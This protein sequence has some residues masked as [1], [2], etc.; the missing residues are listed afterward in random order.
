[1]A[2]ANPQFDLVEI[3]MTRK[4]RNMANVPHPFLN[5]V[6]LPH[7]E[8]VLVDPLSD[9]AK[10]AAELIRVEDHNTIQEILEHPNLVISPDPI[11]GL[12]TPPSVIGVR[13]TLG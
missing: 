2:L 9:L 8:V 10:A 13:A 11:V 6:N 1:M 5:D 7:C 3:D 4:L 12:A